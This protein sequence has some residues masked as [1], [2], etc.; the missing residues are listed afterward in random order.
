M[1]THRDIRIPV[2]SIH[3]LRRSLSRELGPEAAG[4]GLQ[5]AGYAAGDALFERIN[6]GESADPGS[7]P[8][9]SFWNRLA[10]VFRELGWGR[11][12][13]EELHPGV[14]SLVATEW[15]EVGAGGR[16]AACPFTTG[17]LANLLG[18]VAGQEV[19]VMQADGPDD[20]A[21][22]VR[23]LFGSPDVLNEVYTGLREG[24]D[25]AAALSMLE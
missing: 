11:V 8:I 15:F 4:H 3:A 24:R 7:T 12:H 2:D 13:H 19:A 14:G 16:R 5:E 23:F 1:A 9:S 20:Q 6:R 18:H 17:V 25:V 22:C 21:G 10:S